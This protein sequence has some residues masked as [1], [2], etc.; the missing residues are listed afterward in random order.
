MDETAHAA[1][2]LPMSDRGLHAIE[3]D[4]AESWIEDWVGVGLAELEDY[5]TKHARFTDYLEAHEAA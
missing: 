3:D 1:D 2:H 5:L 4:L